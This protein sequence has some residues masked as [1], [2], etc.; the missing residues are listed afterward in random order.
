M[1]R[2]KIITFGC[3]LNAFESEIMRGHA[4]AAG[5]AGAVIVN[6]CAVTAEAER[7]TRQAI[8]RARRENPEARIIVTGCAAQLNAGAFAAMAEVDRVLGNEEK[9]DP[10]ILNGGGAPAEAADLQPY[11]V[12]IQFDGRTIEDDVHLVKVVGFTPVGKDVA[13]VVLRGGK[14]VELTLRLDDR[15][16]FEGDG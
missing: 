12:V 4:E 10:A 15:S 3:R 14:R 8:R 9:L 16:R 1:R 13:V 6:S 2:A 11:D 7:Q 5:L